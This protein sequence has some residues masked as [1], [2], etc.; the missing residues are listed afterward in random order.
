M[1]RKPIRA[2]RT[3]SATR[4]MF[5][6]SASARLASRGARRAA[7]AKVIQPCWFWLLPGTLSFSSIARFSFH[8]I[9]VSAKFQKQQQFVAI[10]LAQVD[11]LSQL[12]P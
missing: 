12:G 10:K 4:P 8:E 5:T 1:E 6:A 11:I 9:V 7:S 3:P 2:E